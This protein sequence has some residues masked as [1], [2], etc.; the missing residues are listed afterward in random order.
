MKVR[1]KSS[2][3]KDLRGIKDKKLH[4]RVEALIQLVEDSNDLID[5]SGLKKLRGPGGYYRVR[6]SE[7][8]FP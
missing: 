2:F 4:K 6:I 8:Y 7:R 3:G 1:F 5:V